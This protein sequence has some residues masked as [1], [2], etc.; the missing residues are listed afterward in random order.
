MTS[1]HPTAAPAGATADVPDEQNPAIHD[2]KKTFIYTMILS[3]L[4]IGAGAFVAF[5]L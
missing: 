5:I 3:A 1:D 2:M 4:F